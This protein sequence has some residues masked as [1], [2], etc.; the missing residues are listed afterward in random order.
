LLHRLKSEIGD[1]DPVRWKL[2]YYIPLERARRGEHKE[3]KK[4]WNGWAVWEKTEGGF[5]DPKM[6]SSNPSHNWLNWHF[7]HLLYGHKRLF[8]SL[9]EFQKFQIGETTN[10]QIGSKIELV[11]LYT[12]AFYWLNKHYITILGIN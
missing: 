2:T 12:R 9:V 6:K 3:M 1:D 5:S 11:K 4:L 7:K 10:S 8:E